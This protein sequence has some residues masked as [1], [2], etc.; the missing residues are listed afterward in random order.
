[1][2]SC[3]GAP[4][5][6]TPHKILRSGQA[7][8]ASS[9]QQ[10]PEQGRDM[11]G[12]SPCQEKLP[13]AAAPVPA[14]PAAKNEPEQRSSA[15][16]TPDSTGKSEA[17][18]AIP[19]VQSNPVAPAAMQTH[20]AV[21]AATSVPRPEASAAA[22]PSASDSACT[23]SDARVEG[24]VLGST[25]VLCQLNIVSYRTRKIFDFKIIHCAYTYCAAQ[26]DSNSYYSTAQAIPSASTRT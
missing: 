7:Q 5:P 16:I 22:Q 17:T 11:P 18:A 19:L 21:S 23:Q 26:G 10:E 1:M 9:P 6:Q 12:P 24:Y 2:Q 13:E 14:L 8:E 25:A 3:S 20:E 15:A 4:A